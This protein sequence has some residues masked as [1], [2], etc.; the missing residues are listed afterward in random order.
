MIETSFINIGDV[1]A[2]VFIFGIIL[3]IV[4]VLYKLIKKTFKQLDKES[5]EKLTLEQENS[6]LQSQIGELNER[7]I[8]L[9][10]KVKELD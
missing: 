8:A 10:E 6:I 1:I 3:I 5:I 7:L 4:A 9:E 2:S